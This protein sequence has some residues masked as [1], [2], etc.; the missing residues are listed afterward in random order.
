LG[1]NV[2]HLIVE[3]DYT[4]ISR[5]V[6]L[7]IAHIVK[8]KRRRGRRAVIGLATGSSPLGVYRKLVS[9]YRDG[10]VDFSD[11]HFFNLD[12]YY[13]LRRDDLQSFNRFMR[14]NFF[15]Y[16]Q[17][18]ED[19]INIPDG[20]IAP[21]E[22]DSYCEEYEAKIRA[23]GGIDFQL[24]GIGRDGHI[25]F[26]EP[27]SFADSRTRLVELN[28]ITRRDAAP[29]FFGMKNVPNL[30][31]TMGVATILE[32]REIVLLVS[33]EH[34][35]AI[36]RDALERPPS[37]EVPASFLQ[38]HGSV[39]IL[40]DRAAASK[41]ISYRAPWLVRNVDWKK[42]PE[43]ARSAAISLALK[44]NK[45]LEG[46][47]RED[48]AAERLGSLFDSLGSSFGPAVSEEISQKI[49]RLSRSFGD[50]AGA[51]RILILS[52]H[53]D[54]DVICAGALMR[55]IKSAKLDLHVAYMVSGANAVRDL[56]VLNYLT[57]NNQATLEIF[58]RWAKSEGIE[59]EDAISFVKQLVY[60]KKKGEA[61]HLVLR[62]LKREIR[63]QEATRASAKAGAKSHFLNLPF[64]E[65]YGS[66]R[67]APVS[68]EDLKIV[69]S[70]L[71][72]LRPDVIFVAGDTTDPN[73][74]HSMCLTAFE[75]ALR[76]LGDGFRPTIY[77]YRGAWEEF[78]LEESH[79]IELFDKGELQEK[80][81]M[82]L[83]HVSQIDPLFPGPSDDRQFWERAR[84]RN[85]ASANLVRKLGLPIA[86]RIA[87]AE[88]Y[89]EYFLKTD[90]G[91]DLK[92][93]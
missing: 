10:A 60:S 56:D 40:C 61:D 84:D 41:L 7:S 20:S 89:K 59:G 5:H 77:Q 32:A 35:S 52:P 33:G 48:Y 16:I 43:L 57:L 92:G 14:E 68:T 78:T 31:I 23:V 39:E 79:S 44:R 11:C 86:D 55:K 83:E 69:E 51:L 76:S 27:G 24:L 45:T 38:Y 34:K 73:G 15:E 50:R 8:E 47:V 53:P 72:E 2:P 90:T 3:D 13:G 46:L 6:A 37:A 58:S 17:A 91:E 30:A 75:S 18:R 74:T 64:Y 62:L 26:N 42:E 67:K 82:I 65:E 81:G 21:S 36:L 12:E 88:L 63:R 28:E 87:G 4:V 1:I 9:L 80:I 49:N 93:I 66:A 71:D 70:F 25:G 19:Q 29:D 54:D 85:E 22:V